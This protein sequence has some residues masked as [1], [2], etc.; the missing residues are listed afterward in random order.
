MT[1][2]TQPIFPGVPDNKNTTFSASSATTKTL[3][4][5]D[6]TNGGVVDAL[7]LYF[8]SSVAVDITIQTTVGGVTSKVA[9]IAFTPSA[10]QAINL[11]SSTYLKFIDDADPKWR[12]APGQTIEMTV[13]SFASTVDAT[14]IGGP[15]T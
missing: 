13:T 12:L 6:A 7:N 15:L 10:K 5:A 1:A 3:Y 2:R 9:N 8:G 14:V 4:T 11:I